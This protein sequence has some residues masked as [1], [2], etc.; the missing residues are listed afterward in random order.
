MIFPWSLISIQKYNCITVPFQ[1]VWLL[2]YV[3][4]SENIHS[5]VQFDLQMLF[6]FSF[7]GKCDD[8]QD[9]IRYKKLL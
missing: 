6:A 9:G 4:M 5:Y 1:T 2:P 3:A 8:I 7:Y